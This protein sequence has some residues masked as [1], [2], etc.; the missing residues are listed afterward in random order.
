VKRPTTPEDVAGW[1]RLAANIVRANL[2]VADMSMLD[3][4][5]AMRRLGPV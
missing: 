1:E 3:L 4:E 2:T 5:R